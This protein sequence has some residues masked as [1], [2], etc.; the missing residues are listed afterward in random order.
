MEEL[1]NLMESNLKLSGGIRQNW[2][3]SI[4]GFA[5]I[6]V[7]ISHLPMNI[8]YG[9]RFVIGRIG[10]TAFF[11]ISG[12]LA[13]PSRRRMSAGRYLFNRFTR[14][15][16]VYWLLIIL[17]CLAM[18]KDNLTIWRIGANLTCFQQFLGQE[19]IL[20]AS[21]MLP[22]QITFFLIVALAGIDSIITGKR[23]I[24]SV[25]GC[26]FLAVFLG[27]LRFMTG[28]PFPT[29]FFLLMN[30]ALLG[31]CIREM[32]EGRIEFRRMALL[33]IFF[34]ITLMIAVALSYKA[35]FLHYVG[36]YNTGLLLVWIAKRKEIDCWILKKIETFGYVF[37]LGA[38]IPYTFL[39]RF[40]DFS[41]TTGLRILGSMVEFVLAV[42][43]AWAVTKYVENPLQKKI[44]ALKNGNLVK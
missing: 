21:W 15:Y 14:I 34:E 36:A 32:A 9:M 23:N 4:K 16:P 17:M 26:G 5:A 10:V 29:A 28:K 24:L 43:F 37:F 13:V 41:S 3:S 8:N 30:V 27:G 44:K 25:L 39:E 1:G 40:L 31:M 6:L 20:S 33:L 7:F 35:M 22:I 38:G 18:E 19:N 11:L 12:Y 2:I 42:L